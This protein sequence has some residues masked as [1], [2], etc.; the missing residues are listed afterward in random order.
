MGEGSG[1]EA[2][3]GRHAD[4]GHG[5][6]A[7]DAAPLV[8]GDQC[9]NDGVAGSESLHHAEA[10]YDHQKKRQHEVM[11]E[12]EEDQSAAEHDGGDLDHGGEAADRFSQSQ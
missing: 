3:K 7:H 1:E 11:R 6:V 2:A 10:Y 12:A 8:F 4:E 9:L 5:V